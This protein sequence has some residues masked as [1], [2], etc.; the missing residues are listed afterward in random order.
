MNLI[1]LGC[2]VF[3]HILK[4]KNE[5]NLRIKKSLLWIIILL[6]ITI[7]IEKNKNKGLHFISILKKNKG[8]YIFPKK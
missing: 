6:R 8:L 5:Q 2:I 3:L 4:K 1:Y 7:L